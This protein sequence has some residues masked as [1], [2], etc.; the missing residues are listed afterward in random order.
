[1]TDQEKAAAARVAAFESSVAHLLPIRSRDAAVEWA[2]QRRALYELTGE[3]PI[4]ESEA[5]SLRA[6]KGRYA[7]NRVFVIGNG[8]SL[9]KMN[10]SLLATEYTFA[11]NRFYLM[12]DRIEW[13]PTFYTA[14]DWRVVPDNF[15]EINGLSGSVSFYDKRYQGLLVNKPDVYW[16][17]HHV[18]DQRLTEAR[19][20]FDIAEGVVGAGSVVGSAIQIAY[21]LG[22]DP[23]YLIGCDL[24]Y[25]V[26]ETVRQEGQDV[27]GTG[28]RQLLTSTKND[29][30]NH[31]DPRYFGSGRRWHDPNVKRMVEG[32][33]QCYDAIA[34]AGGRIYNAT[35]GGSLEVYPRVRFDTLF[36]AA[37]GLD[38]VA[39]RKPSS[40]PSAN[41]GQTRRWS[42]PTSQNV[43]KRKYAADSR[44]RSA[45]PLPPRGAPLPVD[46][47]ARNELGGVPR[48]MH[49]HVDETAVVA[50]LLGD[51]RG[52][53]HVMLDVGAHI[54]TSAI[55]F[56]S[57]GWTV[58]CFEP[59]AANRKRLIARYDGQ[60]TVH[61][62]PRAVSDEVA[63]S[64]P[65]FSS[66]VSTGISSLAPFHATHRESDRVDVTTIGAIAQ[67]Q[68]IARV[69]FLKIDVEGLDLAV[70]KGVPWN[71]LKPDVIE[72]EF[73]DTKTV[74]M[75]HTWRDIA[76]YLH[77]NG[78]TV[79]VSEWHPVLRYGMRHDWRRVVELDGAEIPSDAWG[80]LLAFTTDPG[81]LAVRAAFAE[82]TEAGVKPEGKKTV[83][84]AASISRPLYAP[85]GDW[86]RPHSPALY[87]ALQII[88]RF[89]ADIWRHRVWTVPTISV[90]VALSLLGLLPAFAAVSTL[91]WA[92]TALT[93]V[94]FAFVYL[95]IRVHEY[96]S[97]LSAEIESVRGAAA[98]A[99]RQG[100]AQG[101]EIAEL[102][103][104]A[105]ML[106]ERKEVLEADI[107][108]VAS[109]AQT[110]EAALRSEI[111][112]VASV[113]QGGEAALKAALDAAM[114]AAE[115][116]D[117]QAEAL[118]TRLG[119]V[120]SRDVSLDVV[121][122]L[123]AMRP[124][125]FGG[126]AVEALKQEP[127]V[128][129]GHTLLMAVLADMARETPGTLAGKTLIEIGS[130]RERDPQQ[131][132]TEK[133]AIFTA[134][135]GMRFFSV[136]MDARNT[137]RA[138]VVLRYLN[139]AGQALTEKGEDYLKLHAGT[140]DAVYL[141]AFDF[142]HGGHSE[143][144][145]SRYEHILHTRINDEACWR[146]HEACAQALIARMPVGGIV[147]LDDTWT[148]LEGD[149]AG[150]GKLAMPLLLD[151]GFEIIAMTGH[152]IALRRIEA[153]VDGEPRT[154][155][156]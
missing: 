97:T 73:E 145:Q 151:S 69:D 133:L 20:S 102:R 94:S 116:R 39:I 142:D 99:A 82:L 71:D 57:L 91:A 21:F 50:R 4:S 25:S 87:R 131:G 23:I 118:E 79:Y 27:F 140:L 52:R 92:G 18:S 105:A 122:A 66:T 114:Q 146:M 14:L 10:L 104:R 41:A 144:R 81:L 24:G 17:S 15:L 135:T 35:E 152:T 48:E 22:F 147:A 30:P 9:T 67:E 13:V 125:W 132:S 49:A 156:S 11:A 112:R 108:R 56:H 29:D 12:Y 77:A 74:P 111:E 127:V 45:A 120:Q 98:A 19:F 123:R 96:V 51:R 46:L 124:I 138:R 113:A 42:L 53:R 115:A 32:H 110:G 44:V 150:K 26:A 154:S 64:V 61:I 100:A 149:Y 130:T 78:Y 121:S 128:E 129:H 70:L 93:V 139:P 103:D 59:D 47:A 62:D 28:V 38:T 126:S 75:G 65:F 7:G 106:S 136:D 107:E 95:A 8:P 1:M 109:V 76:A 5:D 60:D 119:T 85:F 63:R 148:D 153:Q 55:H 86:L 31:F 6:L 101:R 117:R 80:N 89:T 36:G 141:D 16:Y 88:R 137:E 40:T 72:C 33:Q 2:E 3:L 83:K 90:I 143:D 68:G 37:G 54:G 84:L 155:R 43:D 134:M 34:G 58:Y